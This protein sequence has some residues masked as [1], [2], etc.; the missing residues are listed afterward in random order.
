MPLIYTLLQLIDSSHLA[1]VSEG[2]ALERATVQ[3]HEKLKL[4]EGGIGGSFPGGFPSINGEKLGLLDILVSSMVVAYKVYEEVLC[5]KF[6]DSKKYPLLSSWMKSLTELPLVKE[7]SPPHEKNV[8]RVR[9]FRKEALQS[10][11]T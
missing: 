3:V 11:S 7:L 6:I 9:V 5:V 2:E 1:V 4:L 8:N 10:P